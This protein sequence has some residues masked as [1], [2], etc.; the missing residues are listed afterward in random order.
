MLPAQIER[1][2]RRLFDEFFSSDPYPDLIVEWDHYDSET[3]QV[4]VWAEGDWTKERRNALE[5]ALKRCVRRV[6]V[7]TLDTTE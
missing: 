4:F 2:L 5:K 6:L 3:K 7:T 1:E